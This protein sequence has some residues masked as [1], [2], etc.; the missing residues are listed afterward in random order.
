MPERREAADE[1]CFAA[2]SI[3][4]RRPVL[5]LWTDLGEGRD[6]PIISLPLSLLIVAILLRL[7]G[8]AI[9]SYILECD[10]YIFN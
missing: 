2:R 5:G 7:G 3:L 8:S 1:L 10:Y 4:R 9:L 6:S